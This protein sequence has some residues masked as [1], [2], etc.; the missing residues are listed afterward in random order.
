MTFASNENPKGRGRVLYTRAVKDLYQDHDF[1]IVHA[2]MALEKQ[3]AAACH[4]APT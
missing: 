2:I 4:E 1:E 3:L